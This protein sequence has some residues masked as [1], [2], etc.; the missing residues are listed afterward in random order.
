MPTQRFFSRT[1]EGEEEDG[2]ESEKKPEEW[3]SKFFSHQ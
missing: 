2:E 3:G 1:E